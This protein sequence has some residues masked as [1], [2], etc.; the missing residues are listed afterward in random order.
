L[1][2]TTPGLKPWYLL[3]WLMIQAIVS[4][5]VPMSGAGMSMSGPMTSW[6]WSMN[7]RV[8]RS[9]SVRLSVRGS[10]AMPPLAPP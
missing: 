9:F 8:I 4:A 6:I 5:S 7:L 1:P 3:Y 10:T 2:V